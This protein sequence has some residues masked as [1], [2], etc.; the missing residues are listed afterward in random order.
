MIGLRKGG[1]SVLLAFRPRCGGAGRQWQ[2]LAPPLIALPG[3]SP[4]ERGE[5]GGCGRSA[6]S[7][8]VGDWP[9]R[10]RQVPSPRSRGEDG[11]SQM[12]GS[13]EAGNQEPGTRYPVR[14]ACRLTILAATISPTHPHPPPPAG[15]PVRCRTRRLACPSAAT[16]RPAIAVDSLP[17]RL[18]RR[19]RP[20]A[21]RDSDSQ[22]ERGLKTPACR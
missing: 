22:P 6:P 21:G 15:T 20:G 4:R 10:R 18:E 19:Y 17:Y 16:H 1:L 9:N 14:L 13:A 5:R 3:I 8:N 11:G 12:R 7:C 2:R